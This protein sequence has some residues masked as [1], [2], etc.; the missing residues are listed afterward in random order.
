MSQVYVNIFKQQD[1]V[2]VAICDDNILGETFRE[3]KLKLEVKTSFYRGTL[4][5]IGEA[6][7]ALNNASV[8]NLVGKRAVEAAIKEGYVDPGAIISIAG[9]PHVQVIKL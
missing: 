5:S 3:G 6:M 8:G 4:S 7:K 1:H 9:I 2:L